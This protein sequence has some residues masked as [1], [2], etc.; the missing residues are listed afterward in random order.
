MRSPFRFIVSPLNNEQYNNV[1]KV[2]DTLLIVNTGIED[3]L[4]VNRVGIVKGLPMTYKGDIQIDD[5]VILYHN[6][7]RI[8]YNDKGVPM[9]SNNHIKDNL[10]YIDKDLIYMVIRDGKKFATD[11]NVFV[12]PFMV[13]EFWQDEKEADNIG[14]AKYI[15]SELQKEGIVEGTKIAFWKNCKYEFNIDGEKLYLMKNKRVTAILH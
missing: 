1:K 13:K 11:D 14:I 8:T 10:F 9:Q 4:D 5:L 3:H 2:G 6:T 15:N 12:K 7:F